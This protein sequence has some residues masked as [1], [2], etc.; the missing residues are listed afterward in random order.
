MEIYLYK[1]LNVAIL[2]AIVSFSAKAQ[3]LPKVQ[4]SSV[5]APVAVKIDGKVT[6]W[7]NRFQAYN[8]ATDIFYTIANDDK[9]L[10]LIVQATDKEIIKKLV[11]GGVT[12]SINSLNNKKA[13]DGA[14]V[15]FP[16]YDKNVRPL[17]LTL[18]FKSG[19][20][21]DT[22]RNKFLKDSLMHVYNNQLTKE[23]KLIGLSGIKTIPDSVIS[24]Y[25]DD[26]IKAASRFDD[27]LNY[28]YELEIPLKL[29]IKNGQVEFHYDIK[30][31]GA[32]AGGTNIRVVPGRNMLIYTGADGVTYNLGDASPQ[33]M[34][35]AYPT[36]FWGEY[37]LAKK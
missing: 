19:M 1:Q 36:D 16:K 31:N 14:A 7:G 25:N 15:T 27:K 18:D 35:L 17:Y 28:T 29:L 30:L 21:N 4:S 13:K 2:L 3:N 20:S 6:E 33:N 26:G 37:S 22:I 34:N 23:L 12:F 11:V 24:I 32:A 9:S 10:Y 5:R 8:K